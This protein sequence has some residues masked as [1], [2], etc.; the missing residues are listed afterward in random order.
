[1]MITV[2]RFRDGLDVRGA[3]LQHEGLRAGYPA[4]H[5]RFR[6]DILRQN[7]ATHTPYQFPFQWKRLRRCSA[8]DDYGIGASQRTEGLTEPSSGKKPVGRILRRYQHDVE[9]TSQ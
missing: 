5:N 3:Q 4:K 8:G 1:M 6:R 9:I 7:S 2:K